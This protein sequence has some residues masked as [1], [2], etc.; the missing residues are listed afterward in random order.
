LAEVTEQPYSWRAHPAR[1]RR[2]QASLA[3]TVML[4]FCG[5]VYL[6]FSSLA[7]AALSFAILLASL[8]RFFFPSKFTI[9]EEGII[10]NYP[11]RRVRMKWAHLKGFVHDAN[12]GYLSTRMKPSRLDGYMGMHILFG[13]HRDA[14]IERINRQ[15]TKVD[16]A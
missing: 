9:D 16:P 5:F 11:L 14:M 6:A 13:R 8:S 15:L 7:W 2:A 12:G 10:A 3:L 1:D 4:A